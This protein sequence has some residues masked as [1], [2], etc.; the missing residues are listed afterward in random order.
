MADS[1]LCESATRRHDGPNPRI[2]TPD[3]RRGGWPDVGG[4][5]DLRDLSVVRATG[6]IA[7]ARTGMTST[8]APQCLSPNPRA[9]RPSD[10]LPRG[11]R[12]P[13]GATWLQ[14]SARASIHSTEMLPDVRA[15]G[16]GLVVVVERALPRASWP[17]VANRRGSTHEDQARTNRRG[18]R[19][20]SARTHQPPPA[21]WSRR[22]L[23]SMHYLLLVRPDSVAAIRTAPSAA[24]FPCTF[25]SL[26]VMVLGGEL[27]VVRARPRVVP[28]R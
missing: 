5:R 28:S 1:T 10:A 3:A 27:Q 2:S 14:C 8:R 11:F 18:S 15:P 6:M 20:C 26:P 22:P 16:F 9:G 4:R 7:D 24:R 21:R 12:R 19:S 23:P 17:E 13:R 25:C